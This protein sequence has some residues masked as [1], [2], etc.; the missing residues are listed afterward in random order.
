MSFEWDIPPEGEV[1][2]WVRV[3]ER[4]DGAT[5]GPILASAGPASYVDG[6]A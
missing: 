5:S 3:E 4:I 2:L 6:E 1:F